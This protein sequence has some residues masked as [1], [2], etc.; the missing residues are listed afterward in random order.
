MRIDTSFFYQLSNAFLGKALAL[1]VNPDG[2]GRVQMASSGGFAGQLW[3]LV[4]RGKGAYSLR[5]EYLGD[6][7]SLDIINDQRR[8]TPLLAP[9]GDFPGQSWTLLPLNGGSYKLIND[10][11]GP[12]FFLDTA[13]GTQQV[14][15]TPGDHSGQHWTLKRVRKIGRNVAIPDLDPK[16]TPGGEGPTDFDYYARPEGVVRALMVFVDFEDVSGDDGS[17]ETT[18][19][20][21]LGNGSAQRL[22]RDQS[23][24]RMALGVT[25]KSDLGWRRMPR[26]TGGYDTSDFD[27][28]K[29]YIRQAAELFVGD[30][31]FSE[32]SLILIAT[33]ES[34]HL[35]NGSSS[36][37]AAENYG[38]PVPGG[39]IRLA[40]TFDGK[41]RRR[42]YTTLVHEV[43]H[44]FGLPDQYR[45]GHDAQSS[46]AGCWSLMS[47][48]Y[49]AT[50]FLGWD[51]HKNGW[52]DPSRKTYVD[53]PVSSWAGT[54]HPL[55]ADAGLSM[56]VFP[57]D[58]PLKP[59]KVFVL[60]LA[61]TVIGEDGEP[62]G[63]GVLFYTV[64]A[65]V[66]TG[67][68]PVVVVPN[69]RS[70][71]DNFGNLF[72]APY[73]VGDQG[74]RAEGSALLILE[75]LQRFG[76]AYRVKVRYEPS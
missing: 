27:G 4:D 1:D 40:V 43:A 37:S 19:R 10:L 57:I 76:A 59:T 17:P 34:T 20:R 61:Q 30:V 54:L 5:T 60:E 11:T 64:D 70:V 15:L 71:S 44:L 42:Q 24:R 56:V 23:Y 46:R 41:S 65:T 74:A 26:P 68:S 51:R 36:F 52:L 73:G 3:K 8:D 53:T 13:A 48:V 49:H 7:F 50:G 67:S 21:L 33:P 45:Y 22:F 75:V 47:D 72:E 55:A 62:L 35:I 58:D 28:H 29:E 6:G 18:A 63:E 39:E 69:V 16:E 66:P 14:L 32:Y 9:S 25:V 31:D 38:I 2:S 12:D